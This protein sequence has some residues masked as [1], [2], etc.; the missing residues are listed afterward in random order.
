MPQTLFEKWQPKREVINIEL[1]SSHQGWPNLVSRAACGS[2]LIITL[3]KLYD[4][5]FYIL[6]L[7]YLLINL[8]ARESLIAAM[9]PLIYRIEH[10]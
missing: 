6:A 1:Y 5:F 3:Y 9:P 4:L 8:V 10:N 7:P 2:H